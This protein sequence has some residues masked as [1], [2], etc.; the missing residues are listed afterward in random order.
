VEP[1]VSFR[2]DIAVRVGRF[3][4]S[5]LIIAKAIPKGFYTFPEFTGNF[6]NAPRAKEKQYD[7]END[8]Q[9][10]AAW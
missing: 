7:Y 6:A 3:I 5:W 2:F 8:D 1:F 9:F 4:I 10:R